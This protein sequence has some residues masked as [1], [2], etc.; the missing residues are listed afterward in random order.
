MTNPTPAID[1][2]KRV[3][4]YVALRDKIKELDDAHKAKMAPFREALEQLNGMLLKH[5][6][7]V[8][9]DS[10]IT[11][12]GTVYRTAKK[13]ASLADADAFMSYV[14]TT[15]SWDLL[16]RK[17]N[18]SAVEAFITEHKTLPPGVNFNTMHV[19]GVRRK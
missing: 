5:L 1:I 2:E 12:A 10:A 18:V 15:D 3:A 13:S 11:G 17:A 19:V 4:Q 14:I 8:N 7:D 16:D 9:V 6:S